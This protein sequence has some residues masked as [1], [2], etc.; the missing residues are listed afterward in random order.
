[1]PLKAMIFDLDGTLG[2]T[3]PIVMDALKDTFRRYAGREYSTA[4]ILEMFGPSE[5]G[6]IERRVPLEVFPAALQNYLDR[7]TELHKLAC[8]PFPGVMRLLAALE[9]KGIRRGVVTGK[10]KGTAEISMR[11]MRLAPHIEALVTGSA[12][13]AEKDEA[14][15]QMLAAWGIDPAEAAYVGDMP[16]D[17]QAAREAG[18]RPLAAAWALS[19]VVGKEDG[20]E[21]VFYTVDEL[22]AWV[23]EI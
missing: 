13:G 16:Y 8:E 2:D 5:E 14:M 23:E 3:M 1:M 10:G 6:V 19:A 21:Q 11:A 12:A 18:L 22:I 15:R 4:D 7:Y 20:A 9:R 17:M